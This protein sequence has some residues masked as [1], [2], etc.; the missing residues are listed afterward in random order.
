MQYKKYTNDEGQNVIEFI[1][2]TIIVGETKKASFGGKFTK[3]NVGMYIKKVI[4]NDPATIV[5]WSD[6]TKTVCKCQKG[7]TYNK[8]MGLTLC[9]LKKL[10][11]GEQVVNLLN[12]WIYEDNNVVD[13]KFVRFKKKQL[14][15]TDE[16][17]ELQI[18]A[19]TT[20]STNIKSKPTKK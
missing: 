3:A 16:I 12:D 15:K 1:P 11:G 14:P 9:V 18:N 17:A 5:F 2:T 6:N 10:V 13:L 20:T 7:D 19:D 4:Y 8:E